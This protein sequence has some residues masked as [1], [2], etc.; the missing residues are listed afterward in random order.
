MQVVRS[1]KKKLIFA[2]EKEHTFFFQSLITAFVTTPP[3]VQPRT[4][5]VYSK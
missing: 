5:F 2:Q 4:Q 1:V 3:T